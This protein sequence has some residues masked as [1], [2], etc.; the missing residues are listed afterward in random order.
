MN[1]SFLKLSLT[2]KQ[3]KNN[4]PNKN[5]ELI[6]ILSVNDLIKIA[7]SIKTIKILF[8]TPSLIILI[9]LKIIT[10]I[11]SPNRE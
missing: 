6:R 9:I 3:V 7:I 11:E 8:F 2:T 4:V 1:K 10:R 5:P